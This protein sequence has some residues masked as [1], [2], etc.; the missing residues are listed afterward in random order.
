MKKT[1]DLLHGDLVI[2]ETVWKKANQ[3][4][5]KIDS[6]EIVEKEEKIVFS[7]RLL[8]VAAVFLL[9]GVGGMGITVGAHQIRSAYLE[10]M[11]QMSE[12]EIEHVTAIVNAQEGGRT[13]RNYTESEA[14]R[15]EQLQKQYEE[16]GLF[17]ENLIYELAEGESYDGSRI[18]LDV[19]ERMIYLP[20]RELTDEELLQIIDMYHK[21]VY[22]IEQEI[23]ANILKA[24]PWLERMENVSAEE[25]TRVYLIACTGA[26]DVMGAKSR[27]FSKEEQ[28]NYDKLLK[29]YEQEN[30]IPSERIHIIADIEDYT[31][32]TVTFCMENSVYYLPDR[33]LE[34]VELLQIID[35][36]HLSEY[37]LHRINKEVLDGIRG[38]YPELEVSR[39]ELVK[40]IYQ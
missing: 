4:L 10:R 11:E 18:A 27:R 25:A 8:R 32:E 29:Q 22:V 7:R 2:P 20:D 9:V 13:S 3:A 37:C 17:P 31:G 1:N 36:N 33:E 16:E 40:E 28:N 12:K 38:G 24:N 35:F 6:G 34:E 14:K 15:Y 19:T 26:A 30:M 21:E 23:E 39:E 5:Q